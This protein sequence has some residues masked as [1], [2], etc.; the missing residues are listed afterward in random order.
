MCA[1]RTGE[2]SFLCNKYA[3][4]HKIGTFLCNKRTLHKDGHVISVVPFAKF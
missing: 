1:E 2:T 4:L 3:V